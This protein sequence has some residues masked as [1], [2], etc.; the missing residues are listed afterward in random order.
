MKKAA[1][2]KITNRKTTDARTI[3]VRCDSCGLKFQ[4]D[5]LK[6]GCPACGAEEKK[7]KPTK[8]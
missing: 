6:A 2:G 8:S 3:T 7:L 5:D 4:S 1:N